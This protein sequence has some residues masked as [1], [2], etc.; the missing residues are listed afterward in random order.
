MS[1]KIQLR[2]PEDLLAI[3]DS[4]GANRSAVIL[5]A[6]T[7]A[8]MPSTTMVTLPVQGPNYARPVHDPRCPCLTCRPPSKP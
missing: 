8:F 2:I 7:A 4:K 6:L 5:T 3:I 1:V